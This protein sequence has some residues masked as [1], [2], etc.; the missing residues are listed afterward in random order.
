M[1]HEPE[2]E[3]PVSGDGSCRGRWTLGSDRPLH[4]VDLDEYNAM[5]RLQAIAASRPAGL[6]LSLLWVLIG[7]ASCGPSPAASNQ[8]QTFKGKAA[9]G[10]AVLPEGAALPPDRQAPG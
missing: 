6:L 1:D 2:L 4:P 5:K 8:R 3:G 9:V 7:C 10:L